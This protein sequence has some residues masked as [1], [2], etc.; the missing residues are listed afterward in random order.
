MSDMIDRHTGR[1]LDADAR[2]GDPRVPDRAITGARDKWGG[3]YLISDIPAQNARG[4][5]RT[6]T[7]IETPD[8]GRPRAIN[9][10]LRWSPNQ[11]MP[12]GRNVPLT[13]DTRPVPFLP[14]VSLPMTRVRVRIRRSTD[15]TAPITDDLYTL[16]IADTLPIDIV[17]ARQLSVEVTADSLA[18][19]LIGWVEAIACLVDD[20][21]PLYWSYPYAVTTRTAF[22]AAT[23]SAT[24]LIAANTDR[25]QF[26]I[27]NMSSANLLIQFGRT[28]LG[29]VPNA[30]PLPTWGP[31]PTGTLYLSPF[32]IYESPVGW[33]WKGAVF[34]VWD[35]AVGGQGA[36]VYEGANFSEV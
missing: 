8:F 31:P 33:C 15:P 3:R 16:G 35:A 5:R 19:D 28:R 13:S 9:V 10:Q 21:G 26:V 29:D 22:V 2:R 18:G 17:T 14:A 30:G 27:S 34:G 11:V 12:D 36:I 20:V 24:T 7:V 32:S 23:T 1:L 25:A 4:V 6:V